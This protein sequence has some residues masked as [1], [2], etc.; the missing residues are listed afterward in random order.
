M[1]EYYFKNYNDLSRLPY[2]TIKDDRLAIDK[3]AN[4]GPIIDIHTH[5]ALAY[6][7]PMKVNLFK[8]HG[9]TEYIIIPDYAEIHLEKYANQDNTPE[10]LKRMHRIVARQVFFKEG[11][12]KTHNVAHLTR[13]MKDL[14]IVNAVILPVDFPIISHNAKTYTQ[15]AKIEKML[16]PFGSVHPFSFSIKRTLDKQIKMGI[17][18]IK[19]HPMGQSIRPDHRLALKLYELCG[20]RNILVLWHCGPVGIEPKKGRERCQVKYYWPAVKRNPKTTFILGHSGALQMDL[21][22]KMAK[23]YKN[24]YCDLACQSLPGIKKIL[25][26]LDSNRILFGTDWPWYHEALTLSKVLIATEGNEE[27]RR[28]VLYEN[29][30]NLLRL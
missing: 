16:I 14:G 19:L 23:K 25:K 4:I 8:D 3:D 12:H 10:L 18:G 20:E 24:C 29:A 17:K 22:L 28:K 27:L 1:T 26:E 5:L 7:V 13:E 6:M 2:F 15:A 30:K 11:A 21:A 9:R